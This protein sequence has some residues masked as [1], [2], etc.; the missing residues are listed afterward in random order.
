M[1]GTA[2]VFSST[3]N[4]QKFQYFTFISSWQYNLFSSW[5]FAVY[6]NI[7]DGTVNARWGEDDKYLFMKSC[8]LLS[9]LTYSQYHCPSTLKFNNEFYVLVSD[10]RF[11]LDVMFWFEYIYLLWVQN[12][13][14]QIGS[15]LM[16]YWIIEWNITK[17]YLN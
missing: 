12:F 10:R 7:H 5:C 6:L 4:W 3:W 8:H 15:I 11:R 16:K 17:I 9:L 14:R 1:T 13:V 2:R